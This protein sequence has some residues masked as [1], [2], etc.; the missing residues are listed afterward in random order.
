MT[1]D[2]T[3]FEVVA[4]SICEDDGCTAVDVKSIVSE[5]MISLEVIGDV[6]LT[7]DDIVAD[8]WRLLDTEIVAFSICV[9]NS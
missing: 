8:G 1:L 3:E 2:D 4:F 7:M 9:V 5:L 6:L